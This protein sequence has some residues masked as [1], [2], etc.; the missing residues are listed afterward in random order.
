RPPAE[1]ERSLDERHLRLG[2]HQFGAARDLC[3][4]LPRPHARLAAFASALNHP[5]E[6]DAYWARTERLAPTDPDLWYFAGL[7]HFRAGDYGRAWEE[8]RHCL[9]LGRP[10]GDW[11]HLGP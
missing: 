8:W 6:I 9:E 3:P 1:L 11:A 10:R 7:H 4:L 2:L 5:D